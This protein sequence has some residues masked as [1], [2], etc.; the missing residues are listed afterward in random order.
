MPEQQA[1]S[2]GSGKSDGKKKLPFS[3]K[4]AIFLL[5]LS[6]M[7]FLSS[8]LVVLVCMAPTVVA[9]IVDKNPQRTLW[10]TIGALNL[11]GTLPAWFRLWELGGSIA[12]MTQVLLDPSLLLV[13]YGGAGAGWAIHINVTPLVAAL[14]NRRNEVVLRDVEKRQNELLRKWGADVARSPEESP[15][16]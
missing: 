10:L 11:A 7:V 6:A 5:L 13:A 4:L 14:M 16:S 8:T 2:P 12:D 15:G 3:L 1:K 9:S